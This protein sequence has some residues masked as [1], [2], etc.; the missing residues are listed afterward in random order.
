MRQSPRGWGRCV[1]GGVVAYR[2]RANLRR[3]WRV[4]FGLA[5][6]VAVLGGV[7]LA[8]A[9]GARRTSSAYG[10]L[11]DVVNPPE[12]L[13]SPPGGG[14]GFDPSPFYDALARLPGVRRIRVFAGI[15]LAP[16]AGT[17]SAR[18]AEALSGGGV[19]APIGDGG[20]DIGRPRMVSGRLP[21]PGHADEVMVSE[22]FARTGDVDVGD[23]IDA[24]ILTG[25][26]TNSVDLVA[27]ADQ[28]TP[29]RLTVTGIGVLH[30][31]VVPFDDLS[32]S[33]TLRGTA[34]LSAMVERGELNFE[35]AMVDVEPGTDLV[36]LTDAIEDLGQQLDLG[37]G[38]PVFVSDQ[39]AAV[40]RTNDAMRPLAFALGVAAVAIGVVVLLVVGQAVS[41]ASRETSDDVEALRSIGSRSSDR[42][43]FLASRAAVIGVAG[44]VGAVAIALALSDRFP[45]GVAQVAEPE[46]GLRIDPIVLF[47]GACVIIAV[48]TLSAL[49]SARLG[50]HRRPKRPR[51]SRLAGA[52]AA[53]GLSPAAVQGV[54]FAAYGGGSRSVP[55]RSTLVAVTVA[56]VAVVATVTFAASLVALVDTPSRYGQGWDRMV[57]AQFG[58]APVTRV[59]NR[60]ATAPDVRGIGVGN[61]GDVTVNGVPVAAF[62]LLSVRGVVSVGIVEGRPASATNE[63]VLGGETMDSLGVEVGDHV[64][65]DSGAGVEPMLITGRGVFPQMGQGSFSTTGLGNGAQLAG[66]SLAFFGFS[67]QL[68]PDYELEGRRYNFVAIDIDGDPSTMDAD[69]RALEAATMDDGAFAL[70][71]TEQPPTK[72]R[73]LDRVRVVPAMMA[74]VLALIAVAAL[75]HLLLTSVRERRREL[76]LLRTLGFSRWQL[77][78]SVGWHASVIAVGALLVG[79]PLGIALG[80]AVWRWYAGGLHAAAPAETPWMWLA[81]AALTTLAVANLVAAIPGRSA[82]RTSPATI[83][84]EE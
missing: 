74:T 31:E 84:R 29:I 67:E 45:F 81:V 25:A 73:D 44:A 3:W 58:P 16:Q 41:R 11:L 13:V 33:G 30:E 28:G 24:V 6:L 36:A 59:I 57:D 4:G 15:P 63:I 17:S 21:N 43:A 14:P 1:V 78:A 51:P 7:V 22:R 47:A 55:L 9:A 60:L 26:E 76:A 10:R 82:A 69:L 32:A 2:L 42:V 72:I 38:G 48:T 39:A 49:P 5:L 40:R 62:D 50:A 54:R 70:I 12:L 61:Y 37:T 18:L 80:R 27:T 64:D 83:L 46:P 53:S 77:S 65:V 34:E 56:T 8:T 66:G 23:H 68:P 71:R 75:A 19:L 79:A 20:A 35:G 52:A